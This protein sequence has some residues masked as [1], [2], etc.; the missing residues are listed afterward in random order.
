MIFLVACIR[1]FCFKSKRDIFLA[2]PDLACRFW[3]ALRIRTVFFCIF[4]ELWILEWHDSNVVAFL[5]EFRSFWYIIYY[6]WWLVQGVFV[7]NINGMF[8]CQS[9]KRHAVFDRRSEL[10]LEKNLRPHLEG[11]V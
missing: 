1:S 2:V 9:L 7:L 3:P 4:C 8:F 11:C 6:F 10:G 5:I